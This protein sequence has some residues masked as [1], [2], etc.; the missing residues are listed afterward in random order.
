MKI[1]ITI[2]AYSRNGG[3]RIILEW[4]NRLSVNHRVFLRCLKPGKCDW[5]DI[6]K[7]VFL[8]VDNSRL[9]ECDCL[10]ITSPHSIH[11]QDLS[12]RPPKVFVFLQMAE[13]LFRPGDA[14]WFK[15][16]LR[17]YTSPHPVIAISRWNIELFKRLGRTG[18]TYYVGNGVNLEDF[19]LEFKPK[20]GRTILV[21]SPVP[22]NPSKDSKMIGAKVAA[23]LRKEGFYVIGYGTLRPQAP[24]MHLAF[25]EFVEKPNTK[26]LN[27]LYSR[28]TIMV[29]ATHF[30]ARSCSP[31]EAMTKGTVTAR[32]IDRG[33]DDLIDGRNCLRSKYDEGELYKNAKRLLVDED[34]RKQLAAAGYNH[35]QEY[36]W[37]FWMDQI[38]RIIS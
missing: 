38:E 32:A 10:I 26:A 33:D 37:P 16:C 15:Q 7:R 5:F 25:D 11:F 24:M 12:P 1:F 3:I 36:S 23:R 19:P 34:L 35:L 31:M 17:S 29:K 4:A 6:S 22:G 2:P 8:E 30:D 13:H 9:G 21:E 27:R 14:Q 28:A 20:D 18:E